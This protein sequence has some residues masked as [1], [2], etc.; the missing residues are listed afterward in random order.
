VV[1]MLHIFI[2][3]QIGKSYLMMKALYTLIIKVKA[4]ENCPETFAQETFCS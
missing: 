3:I 1:E 4:P 2:K